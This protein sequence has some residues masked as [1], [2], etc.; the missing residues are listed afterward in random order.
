MYL[1]RTLGFEESYGILRPRASHTRFSLFLAGAN[2]R[3]LKQSL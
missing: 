3:A 1:W 2:S